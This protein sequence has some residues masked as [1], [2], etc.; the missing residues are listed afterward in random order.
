MMRKH[1]CTLPKA[2]MDQMPFFSWNCI[3]LNLKHRD[4]DLVIKCEKDMRMF[5][6]FLV[7]QL[8]TI[9]GRKGSADKILQIM[10]E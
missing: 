10:Q 8:R 9:N 2:E 1:I 4:V 7:Y 6:K 5:I 3:T